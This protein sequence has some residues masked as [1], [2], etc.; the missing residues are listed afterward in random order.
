MMYKIQPMALENLRSFLTVGEAAELLGVNPITLRR[1][2]A[3]GKL[4][5]HRHPI[6]GFRLYKKDELLELLTAL[7]EPRR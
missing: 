2:D 3:Q 4:K 6:T 1:W 5:A 7:N